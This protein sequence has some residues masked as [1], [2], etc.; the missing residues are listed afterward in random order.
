MA[1]ETRTYT[2]PPGTYTF[3]FARGVQT[4]IRTLVLEEETTITVSSSNDG[5]IKSYTISGLPEGGGGG[6]YSCTCPDFTKSRSALVDSSYSSEQ[7]DAD[8]TT[9]NAGADG[10]CKHIWATK[11]IRGEVESVPTDVP[12]P[13]PKPSKNNPFGKWPKL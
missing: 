2:L 7:V 12:L 9:S 8:W 11:L 6:G 13:V 10:D 4:A 1:T 3:T 5:G